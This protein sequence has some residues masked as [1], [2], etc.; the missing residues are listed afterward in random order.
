M[1]SN[2]I[3]LVRHSIALAAAIQSCT[4]LATNAG[5]YQTGTAP[6]CTPIPATP[7]IEASRFRI[8]R[9]RST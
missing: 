7:R 4:A 8:P 1:L 6:A 5:P 3:Q 2:L 9:L